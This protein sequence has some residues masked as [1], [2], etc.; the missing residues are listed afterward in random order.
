[1]LI[2]E[3][4]AAMDEIADRLDARPSRRRPFEEFPGHVGQAVGLTVAATQEKGQCLGRQV[5]HC[6][7]S[8]RRDNH[9]RQAGIM[10]DAIGR[11]AHPAGGSEDAAAPIAEQVAVGVVPCPSIGFQ[12][13]ALERPPGA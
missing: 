10:N 11:Q 1:M 7:L 13:S 6:V 12:L 5:L 4:D 8:G 2:A 3:G 9:I